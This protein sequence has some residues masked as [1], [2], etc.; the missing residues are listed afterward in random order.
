MPS[1]TPLFDAYVAVDWSAANTPKRGK[2][3]IWIAAR[4]RSGQTAISNPATRH[5]AMIEIRALLRRLR[6]ARQRVLIGF[7]FAF[8]WP[9]GGAEAVLGAPGWQ[10]V[11]HTLGERIEDSETN[12]SNRFEV[13][14]WFNREAADG[15]PRFWGHP[16]QHS[17]DDL[18]A[19]S[20]TR[21]GDPVP[22]ARLAEQRCRAKPVWQLTGAG[23]VGSQA[24]T[25]IA[26]L[27][28]LRRDPDF[29]G[30]LA[31]WPF[32]TRFAEA[33]DA[34][35]VIAEIYPSLLKPEIGAGEVPD[36]VQVEAYADWLADI[37][38]AGEMKRLLGAPDDLS[39]SERETVL[40]E[41]GWILGVGHDELVARAQRRCE[42]ATTYLKR[43][44][45][46]YQSSFAII[47]AEADLSRLLESLH[48]VAIRMI[49]ACGMVDL[50]QDIVGTGD[51]VD[52][53]E[54]SLAA[55]APIWCDAEMV[56]AGVVRRG[57]KHGNDVVTTLNDPG[58]RPLA[59]HLG[60]TRSAAAL[61]L[62]AGHPLSGLASSPPNT[63]PSNATLLNTSLL[64][65]RPESTVS[66][67]MT[68]SVIIIG[69]APTALFRLIEIIK[70][71]GPRPAAIIAAPVGFVGAAESKQALIDAN[72][73][74]PFVAVK[75]RRGGSAIASAALNAVTMGAGE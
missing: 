39:E 34:S 45:D 37:D 43:P 57:L 73:G 63:S 47:R 28:T 12:A 68:R 56:A 14:A 32:E 48:K 4:E 41:E 53:V 72:L 27:E 40:A 69:N 38:G 26:R 24:M 62:F 61:D 60:T 51:F 55:G 20:V 33:L 16:H 59:E 67:Q 18:T 13:A 71:G 31:I 6:A 36:K 22:A 10:A 50:A 42:P 2:D 9:E 23:A 52:A 49:H 65:N 25:G 5:E 17:Y 19:T 3:S 54:A 58:T 75:G 11:W 64:G 1:A 29:A 30:D 46:I 74:I 15:T 35:I 21:D 44:D 66:D 8:G 70:A 7:D